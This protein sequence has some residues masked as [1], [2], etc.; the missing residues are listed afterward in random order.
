M[1]VIEMKVVFKI[2]T[3]IGTFVLLVNSLDLIPIFE[4]AIIS[5]VG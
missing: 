1:M 5:L 4:V 3:R 2:I